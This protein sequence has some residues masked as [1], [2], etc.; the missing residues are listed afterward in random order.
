MSGQDKQVACPSGEPF[1]SDSQEFN[2]IGAYMLKAK[3]V[4]VG[5]DAKSTEV[6]LKTLPCIIGRGKE[7]TLTLPHPLVSRQHTELFERDGRLWVRDMGSLNGTF[8]NNKRLESE[9]PLD[10]NQLLTLGNVTF[11][12]VYEPLDDQETDLTP[13]NVGTLR[14]TGKQTESSGGS[15]SELDLP[16]IMEGETEAESAI[17]DSIV[18]SAA[19]S[20]LSGLSMLDEPMERPAVTKVPAKKVVVKKVAEKK[21]T[22][23]KDKQ[24][25]N[26]RTLQQAETVSAEDYPAKKSVSRKTRK[27]KAGVPGADKKTGNEKTGNEKTSDKISSNKKTS[28]S[29]DSFVDLDAGKKASSTSDT[30]KSNVGSSQVFVELDDAPAANKSVSLSSLDGLPVTPA[31]MSFTGMPA[32][33][34]DDAVVRKTVDAVDIDLGEENK[35]SSQADDAGLDSFINKLPR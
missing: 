33:E 11:R 12:A 21:V 17:E 7:A 14:E 13:L 4:V 29:G 6:K 20:G 23:K 30:S 2:Q 27:P 1:H 31:A 35:S 25:A 24:V 9:Q 19:D 3:L 5:G 32:I 10:P 26:P 28:D 34:D 15:E 18:S 8:L 16:D 22:N